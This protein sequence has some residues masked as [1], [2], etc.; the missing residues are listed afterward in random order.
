VPSIVVP[1]HGDQPFWG[2]LVHELGVGPEP[3]PRKG[4]T[5]TGLAC[6][7]DAA[8]GDPAMAHRASVLDANV[9]KED[10]VGATVGAIGRLLG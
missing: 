3:I 1:F 9:R 5:A 2:R 8:L 10:G 7:I 4:L 6:A